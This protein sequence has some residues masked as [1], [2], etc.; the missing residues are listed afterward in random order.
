MRASRL[1]S[2]AACCGGH[3]HHDTP[4]SPVE[5]EKSFLRNVIPLYAKS[6]GLASTYHRHAFLYQNELIGKVLLAL[7]NVPLPTAPRMVLAEGFQRMLEGDCPQRDIRALFE[8]AHT[9]ARQVLASAV[10]GGKPHGEERLLQGVRYDPL[11]RLLAYELTAAC[12]YYYN[13]MGVGTDP[14][15]SCSVALQMLVGSDLRTD[16]LLGKM[17]HAFHD[18]PRVLETGER[19]A[20]VPVDVEEFIKETFLLERDIFGEY[21]FDARADN[22]YL[23]HCLK[24]S[25]IVKTPQSFVVLLDPLVKSCGNFD[26]QSDVVRQGRWV[27]HTLK[28][29]KEDHRLLSRLPSLETIVLDDDIAEGKKMEILV[30]YDKPICMHRQKGTTKET[31]GDLVHTEVFELA[32]ENKNK[33]FF[34]RW[35][36]DQY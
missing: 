9:L 5:V 4:D 6:N 26:L 22:V 17:T 7:E 21:R 15:R 36:M 10:D 19:L 24:L 23:L 13:L 2:C 18:H 16:G 14:Q 3:H 8:E 20:E 28:A 11:L 33:T 1:L 30:Y 25:D 27:R 32:V 31:K 12:D 35:F 29:G 34:E